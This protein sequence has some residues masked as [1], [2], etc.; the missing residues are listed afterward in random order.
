[1]LGILQEQQLGSTVTKQKKKEEKWGKPHML[2]HKFIYRA[3]LLS[4]D[5]TILFKWSH[6]KVTN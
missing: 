4:H 6:A 2:M 5:I 3:K 1:M